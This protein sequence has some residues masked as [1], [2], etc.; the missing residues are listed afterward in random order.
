M[1]RVEPRRP[2]DAV[3]AARGLRRSR[4]G[5]ERGRVQPRSEPPPPGTPTHTERGVTTGR[6]LRLPLHQLYEGLLTCACSL[7][8]WRSSCCRQPR[9][10]RASIRA[11]ARSKSVCGRCHGGDGNGAEMGPS[12]VQ[13]LRRSRRSAAGDADS[14]GHSRA[15]HA[16]EPV[17]PIRRWPR[18]SA[19]CGRSSATRA[20]AAPR[21]LQ[22]GR[23]AAPSTASCSAKG[24]DDLQVRTA[25]GRVRLLRREGDRVREVTSET[26]WPTYNGEPGGNRYTALTQIDKTNVARL[27]PKWMFTVPNAGGLQGTPVVVDGIMYVTAPNEMLRARRRQ[28]TAGL[29]L[30]ARRAPRAPC[31]GTRTA[32]SP[33]PAIASSW[34]PTMRT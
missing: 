31:R 16:A 6:R 12:I 23:A 15:R 8:V 32:A 5:C 20:R 34:R 30:P 18:S 7:L 25:D 10:P 13:R 21:T 4:P 26:G 29:A 17:S 33:S 28:R 22:D 24:F 2:T 27:A 3:R 9:S 14:R 11:G 1:R 19:T